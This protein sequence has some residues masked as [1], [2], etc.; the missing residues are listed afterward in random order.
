ML[1]RNYEERYTLL[2]MSICELFFFC[3]IDIVEL[4]LYNKYKSLILVVINRNIKFIYKILN[5]CFI[6]LF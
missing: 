4:I 5:F 3:L 1:Y 6:I 2:K